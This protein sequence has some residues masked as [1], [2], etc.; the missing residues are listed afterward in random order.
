MELA[1]ITDNISEENNLEEGEEL[2]QGWI[3][4]QD[5]FMQ[6]ELE[7][8]STTLFEETERNILDLINNLNSITGKRK[9]FIADVVGYFIGNDSAITAHIF[10]AFNHALAT[11]KYD[12]MDKSDYYDLMTGIILCYLYEVRHSCVLKFAVRATIVQVANI[13]FIRRRRFNIRL[14]L[15]KI[16]Q[17]QKQKARR[18]ESRKLLLKLAKK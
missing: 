16:N 13:Y 6:H 15:S 12:I 3:L 7:F 1:D 9:A 4:V 8:I 5:A 11:N 17:A 10:E 14:R 18:L 2:A